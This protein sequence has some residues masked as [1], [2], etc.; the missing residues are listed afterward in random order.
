MSYKVTNRFCIYSG[1]SL[2]LPCRQI[3]LIDEMLL[4]SNTVISIFLF[5][6]EMRKPSTVFDS[7]IIRLEQLTK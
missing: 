2:R 7:A 6:I 4:R 1:F 3:S 5:N